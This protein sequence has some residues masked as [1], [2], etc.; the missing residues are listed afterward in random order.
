MAYQITGDG[1]VLGVDKPD[2]EWSINEPGFHFSGWA[3]SVKEPISAFR[4]IGHNGIFFELPVKERPDVEKHIPGQHVLGFAGMVS[5]ESL[6]DEDK[7]LLEFN[8]ERVELPMNV[9]EAVKHRFLKH[10][11]EK[12]NAIE[13]ILACSVCQN[14]EL[15]IEEQLISCSRCGATFSRLQGVPDMR[16]IALIEAQ[17]ALGPVAVSSNGYDDPA[18]DLIYKYSGGLILD[19]G[20]GLRNKYLPNVV[21]FEIAELPT[22]DVLG[23]GEALPFKSDSFDAIFSLAVLEH[24]KDPFKCA[25]EIERVLKPGGNLYVAVPFLQPFHGYPDHYYNMTS[26]G[27]RNLFSDRMRIVKSGVPAAGMPIWSLSWFLRSYFNGLSESVAGRFSKMT[28]EE[29]MRPSLEQ[30]K[31]EYVQDLSERAQDELA[32]VNYLIATK[33]DK[34]GID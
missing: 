6:S 1:W 15:N 12:R 17:V 34:E 21:N 28:V 31:E 26:S 7:I 25:Q 22:T 5:L 29:L 2:A 16:P 24:V 3:A 9:D 10:R 14:E 11:M 8:N 19:N 4:I 30:M 33:E 32:S 23:V 20:S 18:W 13:V 27:L